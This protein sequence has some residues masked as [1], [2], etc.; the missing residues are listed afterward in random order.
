MGIFVEE[1]L[2]HRPLIVICRPTSTLEVLFKGVG[3]KGFALQEVAPA[4][5][6][7]TRGRFIDSIDSTLV[8]QGIPTFP[9]KLLLP[10]F[11][12]TLV[13]HVGWGIVSSMAFD[14]ATSCIA[15]RMN[16]KPRNLNQSS[17]I[18]LLKDQVRATPSTTAGLN[19]RVHWPRCGYVAAIAWS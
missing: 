16:F 4:L 19:A 5:L 17:L 18:A 1:L 9:A 14:D 2:E 8:S 11:G 15:F 12:T 10:H 7:T 3:R 6:Q 13:L